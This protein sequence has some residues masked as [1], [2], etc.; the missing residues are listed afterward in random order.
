M[1]L[2]FNVK[3]EI[4]QK[5]IFI[6]VLNL[7]TKLLSDSSSLKRWKKKIVNLKVEKKKLFAI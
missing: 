1:S 6:E 2:N 5:R 7:N 3:F 4:C